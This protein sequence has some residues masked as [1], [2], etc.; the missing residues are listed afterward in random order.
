[1]SLWLSLLILSFLSGSIPFGLLIA[2]ARGVDIRRHGSGNIGATNV[3]RVLG[4][5]PGLLCFALD[6]LKGLA[7]TLGAAWTTGLLGPRAL[8]GPIDA[9]S[10]W[11][12]LVV[13]ALAI[14]GHMFSPWVGFRGGKG[15]ATGLGALLGVWPFLT[16]PALDHHRQVVALCQCCLV[17]GGGG[18]AHPG[19]ALVAAGLRP[20]RCVALRAQHGGAGAAGHCQAPREPAAPDPRDR[21]SDRPARPRR[22]PRI[23]RRGPA[24]RNL[25][26]LRGACRSA[27]AAAASPRCPR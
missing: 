9:R 24:R 4:R 12:W 19:L 5:G 11:L 27:N 8:P 1:V 7:P 6:V 18:A 2:R 22:A 25:G 26:N 17:R 16:A 14:L 15:V 23:T 20:G 10:A 21:E 13:M 3:W